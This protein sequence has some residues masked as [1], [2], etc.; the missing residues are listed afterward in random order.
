AS[1]ASV[2]G[3]KKLVEAGEVDRDERV[4]CVATGSVMKDPEEA[5]QVSG[6]LIEVEGKK[7]E[8]LRM[9]G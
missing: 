2:A 4:V 7:E 1:A 5:V 8:I 3:L 6:G 9:M